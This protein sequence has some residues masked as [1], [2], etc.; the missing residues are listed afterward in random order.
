MRAVQEALLRR[1]ACAQHNSFSTAPTPCH[2]ALPLFSTPL[3]MPL[4]SSTSNVHIN[5]G[6]FYEIGRD[7]NLQSI[8]LP[9]VEETLEGLE[10]GMDQES[11][12]RLEGP[13]R[14]ANGSGTRML[15][16]N[17]S[18]RRH[19]TSKPHQGG[20]DTSSGNAPAAFSLPYPLPAPS[21]HRAPFRPSERLPPLRYPLECHVDGAVSSTPAMNGHLAS[22]SHST[23]LGRLA[24]GLRFRIR[25]GFTG[26]GAESV[27]HWY[28]EI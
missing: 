6:A 25:I 13:G 2:P 9:G 23:R 17:T 20:Q 3:A 11:G 21:Q 19:I 8:R 10:F 24:Y 4:F 7:F 5:G 18:H 1:I 14:T 16:Y 27:R 28:Q 12:R 26:H 22:E 15:P